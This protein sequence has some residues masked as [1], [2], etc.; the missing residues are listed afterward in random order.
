MRTTGA[1]LA[2]ALACMAGIASAQERFTFASTLPDQNP[3]VQQVLAPWVAETNAAAGE[4]FQIDLLNGPTLANHGNVYDRVT[5]GVVDMG[6]AILGSVGAPFPRTQVLA[7]PFL[8]DDPAVGSTA[9]WDLYKEGM[10]DADFEQVGLVALL[11]LPSSGLHFDVPVED[12]AAV[13]GLRIRTA[14]KI[15]SEMMQALGATPIVIPTPD[16]YQALE[17][18]VLEGMFT[19]W[20]GVV[21]FNLQEVTSYHIDAN[22][23]SGPAGVFINAGAEARLDDAG[24]AA[25]EAA[26]DDLVARL[27]A[28]YVDINDAFRAKVTAMD[29]QTVRTLTDAELASWREK[30]APVTQTWIDETP[31][32]AAILARFEELI[33]AAQPA[34]N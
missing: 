16:V 27:G 18:G 6:W 10:L 1:A 22:L 28:W 19:G 33:A 15:S 31:D 11:A 2:A 12:S 23:A 14:D 9:I 32:G 24:R 7:L 25:L 5:S 30:T 17:Q 29:G 13:E 21:L 8:V 26:G 34:T 20:T 3:L 4:H